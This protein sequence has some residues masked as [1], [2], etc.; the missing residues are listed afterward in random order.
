MEKVDKE[1]G[2]LEIDSGGGNSYK[3][4]V[5]SLL[6]KVAMLS[7][8][9]LRGGYYSFYQTKG[10]SEREIYIQDTREVFSNG[11]YTLALLLKTKFDTA[12]KTD[13]KKFNTDLTGIKDEFMEASSVNEEVVL[14]ESF[15]ESNEDKIL[16]ET[17][18][19]KKLGLYLDLFS[20]VS[21]LL[22]RLNYMEISGGA[23]E[24]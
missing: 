11:V 18:K 17:Y 9:E 20:K 3:D 5:M 24:D 12:M 4:I 14:G 23:E 13:F 22:A 15:Y 10:G 1:G 6:R 2:E 21:D 19:N 16:L 7:C 8:C